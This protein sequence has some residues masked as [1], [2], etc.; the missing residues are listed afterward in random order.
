M[1]RLVPLILNKTELEVV[2]R[3]TKRR[4]FRSLIKYELNCLKVLEYKNEGKRNNGVK[5]V[6]QLRI[7][8]ADKESF[9][10]MK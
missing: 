8:V 9:S 3:K 2:I 5:S 7:S 10:K 1:L 6:F 4:K